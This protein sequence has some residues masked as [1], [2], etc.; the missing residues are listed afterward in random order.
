MTTNGRTGR[1]GFRLRVSAVGLLALGWLV[2]VAVILGTRS[3]RMPNGR[4]GTDGLGE[5]EEKPGLSRLERAV[6]GRKRTREGSGEPG[7]RT[8]GRS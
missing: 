6:Q 5:V 3:G 4:P 8:T 7:R 2:A 1:F